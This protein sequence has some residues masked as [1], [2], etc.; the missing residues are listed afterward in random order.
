ML[1]AHLIKAASLQ[2]MEANKESQHYSQYRDQKRFEYL[3]SHGYITA[4]EY[5]A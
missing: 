1:L 4:P 5:L 2:L 3:G